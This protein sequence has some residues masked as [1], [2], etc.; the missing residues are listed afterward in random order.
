MSYKIKTI[1]RIA[2]EGLSVFGEGFTISHDCRS[3]DA[4]LVRSARIN[5]D[6]FPSLLAVGRAGT[7]VNNIT[8]EKATQRGICVFNTPGA[9]A[10]AVAELVFI[11]VGF[12]A[13]KIG[14]SLKF[15]ESLAGEDSNDK[16]REKVESYKSQFRGIELAGK[17][18]G[19][20]GLGKIGVKVAN[21]GIYH[22]M[23]VFAFEPFPTIANIHNLNPRV[24]IQ[25]NLN[26]VFSNSDVIS[27]HV[28]LSEKTRHLIG[29]N[30]LKRLNN[31]S[32]LVNFSRGEIIDDQA[33]EQAIRE[34]KI[35][36]FISD[37][38]D[39]RL[40]HNE[41]VIFT[42][43]LGASTAESEENCA[44][45]VTNQVKNYLE[46]GNIE[47]SVN[48]PVIETSL[49]KSITNR[50][51]VINRDIPNM[52]ANITALIGKAG[53]NI[54]SLLNESNGEIGYNVI[55]IDAEFPKSVVNE[56]EKV[57]NVIRVRLIEFQDI[58]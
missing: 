42:P 52:I 23:N 15:I 19:I 29:Q 10:N 21:Y 50:L 53:L 45:M 33:V 30:E 20:I 49:Q 54:Q 38:P 22:G 57:E 2:R 47:N 40:F 9:N 41:K 8:V 11:M 5:T 7:G 1:N 32:I 6:D 37:F 25:R 17:R 39:K 26:G 13:R 3:P 14:P 34:G 36:Y 44:V 28:P 48:F 12:S 24:Q 18:L 46:F 56:I 58:S 51:I 16:I 27:V 4:I 43:H 55:D 31:G 35:A